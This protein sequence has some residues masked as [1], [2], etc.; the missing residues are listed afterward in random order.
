MSQES[1]VS[2]AFNYVEHQPLK[3][4]VRVM[5]GTRGIFDY[6]V[7][8]IIDEQ[9]KI[10]IHAKRITHNE[11][12]QAV[13]DIL[14]DMRRDQVVGDLSGDID[15]E[16][17]SRKDE[18]LSE[19][20]SAVL[21]EYT[22]TFPLNL[23]FIQPDID[24]LS[25][26]EADFQPVEQKEWVNEYF[27]VA[28]A[29]DDGFLE[30]FLQVSPNDFL[31]DRFAYFEIQYE[32]RSEGYALARVQDLANLAVGKLNRCIHQKSRAPPRPSRDTAL[33]YETWAALKEPAFYLIFESGEYLF[34]RPMDYGYRRVI[35]TSERRKQDVLD[36][37]SLPKLS[38][39]DAVDADLINGILAYQDGMT[40][41]S[42]RKSF[43][44]FWR[45]I[46]NLSQV[47]TP[48]RE[49]KERSR[50]ALEYVRGKDAV[51]PTLE[52][53]HEEIDDVRNSLAHEGVHIFVGENH[54]NY[55]KSLLDGM[56]E[57]Y[58]QEREGF[59][60]EDFDTFLEYGVEY[61]KG[62]GK[63][64]SILQKSRFDMN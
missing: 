16:F 47:D 48:K 22:L 53:A 2:K 23:G 7:S 18:A 60:K 13:K 44:S 10:D 43:F 46:E 55:V 1:P 45:G 25:V 31:D 19:L 52:K 20:L 57:L 40:E 5:W 24:G 49:V 41:P 54:R 4:D 64:I 35:G 3:D 29:E 61:Q 42:K 30:E 11:I 59:N 28:K 38:E 63:I 37:Y 39:D 14:F 15:S 32:A 34:P 9:F 12:A 58:L 62:A 50:F 26:L 36:F 51:F 56:I 6:H 33:P 21:T 8:T 27:E 17:N